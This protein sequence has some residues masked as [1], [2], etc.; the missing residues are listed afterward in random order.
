V[1]VRARRAEIEA[2][3]RRMRVNSRRLEAHQLVAF[4]GRGGIETD[5]GDG[6]TTL[7]LE[8]VRH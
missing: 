6:E 5:E 7:K 1:C 4:C 3:A 2:H 8:N